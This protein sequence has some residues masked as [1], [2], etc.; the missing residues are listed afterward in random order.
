M[1]LTNAES[2]HVNLDLR[3]L[4]ALFTDSAVVGLRRKTTD[5][6]LGRYQWSGRRLLWLSLRRTK[7]RDDLGAALVSAHSEIGN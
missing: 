6:L 3:G 1:L 7:G 5:Y 2:A 4:S